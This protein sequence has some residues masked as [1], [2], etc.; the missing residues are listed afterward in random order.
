V[1]IHLNYLPNST[2]QSQV[3]FARARERQFLRLQGLQYQSVVTYISHNTGHIVAMEYALCFCGQTYNSSVI[4]GQ[5][6]TTIIS[7]W[8]TIPSVEDFTYEWVFIEWP[9]VFNISQEIIRNMMGASQE[10][11]QGT[12][13]FAYSD[14]SFDTQISMANEDISISAQAMATVLA[15]TGNESAAMEVFMNSLA[16]SLTNRFVTP[17]KSIPSLAPHN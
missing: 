6:L 8:N 3:D 4:G 9:V 11:F 7:T 16:I 14:N 12:E 2:L 17:I 5:T 1:Q 15:Q 10:I 13:F